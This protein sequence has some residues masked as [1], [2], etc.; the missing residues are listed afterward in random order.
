[1]N[2]PHQTSHGV[3][4]LLM[5]QLREVMA[6]GGDTASRLRRIVR[7]VAGNMVAEVCSVYLL[8]QDRLVLAATQGLNPE[9]V[10]KTALKPGEGL[11]GVI[12]KEARPLNLPDARSHPGFAYRP[13]TGEDPYSSFMGVP[14]LRSGRAIGVL[15]VQNV[16][17][18]A[19]SD[20]EVEALQTIAMV[21]A[22]IAA[23][24]GLIEAEA[25]APEFGERRLEGLNLAPGIAMGKAV[26]HEPRLHAASLIADDPDAEL[27]RLN[28]A[29]ERLIGEI[30]EWLEA[31]EHTLAGE[32]REI[33]QTYRMF[34]RDRGWTE[35]LRESV[36]T[37]LTAEAAVERVHNA[38][39]ARMLRQRDPYFRE[40]LH[41]MEDLVYRLMRH[42]T[43]G[44][45]P[46]A[47]RKLPREAVVVARAMGPGELLDYDRKRL[48]AVVLEEA[49]STS[50]V[51][52][53][54]KALDIPMVSGI[55]DVLDRVEPGARVIVDGDM[56][57]VHLDPEK[58]IITAYEE[59]RSYQA[60]R[61]AQFDALRD[62]RA[63]TV[64]GERVDLLMN[65][66][67]L[68]DLPHLAESGAQ[69]IGLFR[70]E[71]QF[72]IASALPRLGTQTKVYREVLEAAGDRPVVFRTL[73]LGA[74][75]AVPYLV[76]EREA[77]PA[78]GW[79]S[80]RMAL[81]RPGLLRYQVRALLAAAEDR[82]LNIMFPMVSEVSEFIEARS[83]VDREVER[84][85]RLGR[86]LPSELRIGTMLEVPS[87]IW[88]LD[89]LLPL[90]DFA[91]VGSNDLLQFLFAADRTNTRLAGRYD[92]LSPPVLNLLHFLVRK[93][94]PH[95]VP[96]T[97][98]G[99]S[100]GRPLEAMALVGLGFRS[101][102]MPPASIGP[103]KAM[104]RS[105]PVRPLEDLIETL[106]ERPDHTVRRELRAFAEEH[107]VCI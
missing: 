2:S 51:A 99:E 103:V 53:V 44:A 75:K 58:E 50:H 100:A 10:G 86:K 4:R 23:T 73:D 106:L 79:R 89:A 37:G 33:L 93:A 87:L 77:N 97:L 49:S 14:I 76:T 63:V 34:A 105:L 40:R 28:G 82:P 81:D 104:I 38:T 36:R 88:Q 24:G 80:L 71:L 84:L 47:S 41:D 107:R 70:T 39:R 17:K 68:V 56:G 102:S 21:L 74:D 15:A 3:P 101:I 31:S 32:S 94:R 59:R 62:E 19:Y 92:L 30:D 12:A 46:G 8:S 7:L 25:A 61:R 64:D 22:E 54:A 6:G 91:S 69:G 35:R 16:T 42:L 48:R 9:A 5:R 67:L 78:L 29:L 66:G 95:E 43:G 72:M 1:M 83:L 65:A 11:V 96:L 52:I 85:Q 18:R 20:E 60:Q 90:T 98:C 27:A 57:E 45:A 26:L 13:E 55:D